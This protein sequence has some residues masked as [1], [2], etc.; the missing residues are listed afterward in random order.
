M[1]LLLLPSPYSMGVASERGKAGMEKEEHMSHLVSDLLFSPTT[2]QSSCDGR[3][4]LLPQETSLVCGDLFPGDGAHT[5]NH[6]ARPG[7]TQKAQ[8]LHGL[9]MQ[10]PEM[11]LLTAWDLESLLQTEHT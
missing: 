1:C 2:S 9:Q 3:F 8:N 4:P 11:F 10:K 5:V 6:W 7:H